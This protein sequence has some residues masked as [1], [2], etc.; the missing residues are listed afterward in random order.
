LAQF[1]KIIT[2]APELD[3]TNTI[4]PLLT[5]H[6]ITVSLGHSQ[7]NLA[8][9]ELA[10]RNGARFITHL[11][12]AML[13]FHH[14]DPHLIGLLSDKTCATD[15]GVYYGIIADSIHTH[16]SALTIAYR[17]RPDG[18]CLVTDAISP[19]GLAQTGSEHQIGNQ[20]IEIVRDEERKV[21]MACI[22]VEIIYFNLQKLL[23]T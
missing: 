19:M 4:I 8:Q 10:V 22:Q 3:T 17:A 11:F 15:G 6:G 23:K 14:R 5:R 21:N 9:G 2:L 13:P 12:N 7:A 20:M 1:T 18:L 16:P